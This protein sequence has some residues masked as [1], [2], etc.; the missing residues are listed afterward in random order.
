MMQSQR[1]GIPLQDGGLY[2]YEYA[3]LLRLE[4]LSGVY[5]AVRAWRDVQRKMMPAETKMIDWLAQIGAM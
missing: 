4:L 5:Q 1:L 3:M 2:S